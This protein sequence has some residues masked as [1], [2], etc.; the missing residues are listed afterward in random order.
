MNE[1]YAAIQRKIENFLK[2]REIHRLKF[3]LKDEIVSADA[4]SEDTLNGT[5]N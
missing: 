3:R 4:G 2:F 5:K 1:C